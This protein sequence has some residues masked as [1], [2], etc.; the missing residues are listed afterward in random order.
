MY[1]SLRTLTTDLAQY[2]DI[3]EN[4]SILGVSDQI[5]EKVRRMLHKYDELKFNNE[6]FQ[7]LVVKELD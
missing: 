7:N 3:K 6:E 4:T 5:R 1:K 2:L